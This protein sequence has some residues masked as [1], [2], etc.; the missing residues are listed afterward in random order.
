VRLATF[1]LG[2]AFLLPARAATVTVLVRE[3]G[4]GAIAAQ[5][6]VLQPTVAPGEFPPWDR[7]RI[8]PRVTGPNGKVVFESVPMGRFTVTLGKI[9]QP[10]LIDP[11][12]NPLA[13]PPQLTIAAE[14]DKVAVEIEVWRG[15]L[16][17][18][19]VLVDRAGVPR[20]AKLV[21]R[22]LDGQPTVELP[23]DALGRVE[24]LLLPGRYEMELEIPPGYLLVD[25][26]WNGESLPGHVVRFDVREDPRTQNVSW[27]LST[28]ALITGTV[29]DQY[30]GCP[31]QIVATL[32]QP[33]AWIAAA[34]QRGGSTF[35]VVPHQ[36]WVPRRKCVYRL[37]LP[38]GRWT[39]RPQGE[40][41]LTSEPE[42]ADVTIASGETRILDFQLTTKDG[43]D[44]KKGRP[45]VVT[46]QSPDRRPLPG[47]LVEVSPSD[48]ARLPADP[49]ETGKTEGYGGSVSF[50]DLP[51][52]SYLIAA[53]RDDFLDATATVKDYDPNAH[54]PTSVTVTLRE[55]AK[56][57]AH[58]LDEKD[59]PV[60]GVELA[61]TRLSALPQMALANADMA[62]KKRHG[63]G[64]SDVTGHIEI[65]GLYSG[66]YRVEAR[67]TGEQS[68]TRFVLARQGS[69][70]HTRS[71]DVR[72]TE[73]ERSDVDLLVLPAASLDGRLACADRGTMPAKVSF[74]LFPA[75]AHVENLWREK[76]LKADAVSAPDDVVLRGDQAD[77]FQLGPLQ[78][79]EYHLAA[80]PNGQVYW[81]WAS[82]ELVP[83]RA[84]VFPVEEGARLDTG[85]IEIECGPVVAILP[86]IQSKEAIPDLTLGRVHATVR[87]SRDEDHPRSVG[88]DVEVHTA[89]A[90]VRRL[91]EGKF[92]ATVTVEHPYLIPPS[93]SV[94]ERELDLTRGSFAEIRVP[95]DRL[96]GMVKVKTDGMAARMTP[97]DGTPVIRPVADGAAAFPGTLPGSYRVEACRDADCSAVT[98][99]WEGVVVRAARTTFLP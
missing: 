19:E 56:L 29:S 47:A 14:A 61:Y 23:L 98:A 73:G 78:P 18:A 43:D 74:R 31:A 30:G 67:M 88:A 54:E 63:T 69:A 53:G 12:A 35:Q 77:G 55:G 8:Q 87:P 93:S 80:R 28:P 20:Q 95:F 57:H 33:G 40:Y 79:G 50:H 17:S 99:T 48:A 94:P 16:L 32:E 91:Q 22:S 86:E 10:G 81:S 1:V 27:Y 44:V 11:A 70:K 2:L 4:A 59:R 45:L 96:G 9:A 71:I 76:D 83:D 84:T 7:P 34:T 58:A 25:L 49:L 85:V 39:V 66:D 13:P 60:Q 97:A 46:V 62:A 15:S 75:T 6:V 42:S 37:W 82:N 26:V 5:Q 52:G 38:D 24:R 92:K 89:R 68:A 36:E 64:L 51:A 72:L 90:F 21:L 3:R 41:V 65:P